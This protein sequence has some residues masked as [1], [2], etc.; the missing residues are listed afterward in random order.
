MIAVDCYPAMHSV[1]DAQCQQCTVHN[2]LKYCLLHLSTGYGAL[3]NAR[4]M[5]GCAC[6]ACGHMCYFGVK[7]MHVWTKNNNECTTT[8]LPSVRCVCA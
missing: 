8:N 6:S 3:C 7:G 5:H 2:V 4:A 1:S